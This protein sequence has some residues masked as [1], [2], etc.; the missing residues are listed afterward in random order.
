MYRI[1]LL[2]TTI[3]PLQVISVLVTSGSLH[4]NVT[5][6]RGNQTIRYNCLRQ[7]QFADSLHSDLT[8]YAVPSAAVDHRSWDS[9]KIKYCLCD[10]IYHCLQKLKSLAMAELS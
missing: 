8:N 1:P 9:F 4:T 3:S 5:C 10:K 2:S 7:P 6:Y